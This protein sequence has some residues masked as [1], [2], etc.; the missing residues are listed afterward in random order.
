MEQVDDVVVDNPADAG[1]GTQHNAEALNPES[2]AGT[3]AGGAVQDLE[4][5]LPGS[6]KVKSSEILA[7]E[8]SHQ[9]YKRME[10]DYTKKTQSL[11]QQRK[12]FVQALGFEPTPEDLQAF[13]KLTK[14][15]K[16]NERYQR[17]IDG[18]LS[19]NL[20]TSDEQPGKALSPM[21]QKI[22][23]LEKML[24]G[25][26]Q[27]Q[28]TKEQ[29]LASAHG[30]KVWNGWVEKQKTQG[31]EITEE[32]N[33]AMAPFIQA[34]DRIHPDWTDEQILDEA[35]KHATIGQVHQQATKQVLQN[36]DKSKKTG[37]VP[38]NP[39]AGQ[40]PDSEKSY[41]DIFQGK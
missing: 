37:T 17:L 16:S 5:E 14:A 3:D 1:T 21:E 13:G 4:L 34:L 30:E 18:I 24:S 9:N 25:F 2:G 41:A 19:D 27:S 23:K 38:I 22:A 31:V 8:K 32:I 12:S 11:A 10:S 39:K 36:A 15:Y 28:Q 29:Q 7:W 6:R 20:E 35:Y 33:S 26:I 40:K